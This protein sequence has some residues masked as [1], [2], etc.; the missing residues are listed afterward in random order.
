MALDRT[1]VKRYARQLVLDGVGM[2]GQERLQAAR[3]LVVGAGGLGSIV[4]PY[5]VAAGVGTVGI[6]EFDQ[7]EVSNLQRQVLY[8]SASLGQDKQQLALARLGALNP[9][10]QLVGHGLFDAENAQ[11]V[12]QHYDLMVDA[13][14]NPTTRYLVNDTAIDLGQRW[15]WGA[16]QAWEGMVS[17]FDGDCSLR[18]VFPALPSDGG[19]AVAGAFGP[20]L[21]VTGGLMASQALKQVLGLE[22]LYRRLWIFDAA[23]DQTRL[24]RL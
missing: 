11:A 24:L 23:S 20:L 14:D 2:A 15:V 6:C 3:V 5:L 19:C 7:L 10:V 8:D 12:A 9:G 13:S 22:T 16:A 21:A 4:L 18:R 1:A 17:V